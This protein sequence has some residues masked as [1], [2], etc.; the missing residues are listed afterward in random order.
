METVKHKNKMKK[1]SICPSTEDILAIFK[2]QKR[3]MRIDGFLKTARLSRACK[4]EILDILGK[5]TEKGQL[6]HLPGGGWALPENAGTLT[7]IFQAKAGGGGY[8][9]PDNPDL[10]QFPIHQVHVRGAWNGDRV[11]AVPPV[12][13]SRNGR[14]AEILKRN[15]EEIVARVEKKQ[16]NKFYCQPSDRK[17]AVIFAVSCDT[18]KC[19]GI[20]VG[21]M[22]LLKP[23]KRLNDSTWAAELIKIFGPENKISVQEAIVKTAHKVPAKFPALALDQAAKLGAEQTSAKGREDLRHAQFVTIDGKDAKD[24]DDAIYV[25]RQGNEWLLLVAIADVSHYVRPDKNPE[26][27]DQEAFRRGNS[28]YFPSSVEPMLPE[29]LSNGLCSLRPGEDRLV[30]FTEIRLS[31]DG[32]V[33]SARFAQGLIRSQARLIYDDVAAFFQ[34]GDNEAAGIEPHIA[35]MLQE[36]HELYKILARKR[37]ERGS[38]DF[39]L[40]EP[41]YDFNQ[42]GE[43]RKMTIAERNDAHKLIEE[44]MISANEA[45]AR[46]LGAAKIPFLYRVHPEPE[47]EKLLALKETLQK[48]G[49]DNAATQLPKNGTF[50]PASIQKIL[51]AAAGT[52][53]EYLVNK[54][55]LR[56]MQQARYQP[57]NVGHFGLASQAYCHFTSP[58]RRYADLLVHRALKASMGKSESKQPDHDKLVE[59]GEQLNNLERSALECEREMARR[60]GCQALKGHE[61]ETLDGTISGVTDFGAF[62]EFRDIPTEGLIRLPDL[63]KDW[64]EFDAKTQSLRGMHTGKTW[65]LGQSLKVKVAD[66]NTDRL[67]IRLLPDGVETRDSGKRQLNN[68]PSRKGQARRKEKKTSSGFRK[69]G[70]TPEK[71]TRNSGQ[72]RKR[73]S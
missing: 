27:L 45:A 40:P 42:E 1:N 37:R 43:L 22:V 52:P 11:R 47:P 72:S 58:I 33:L 3:H 57:E 14:I 48:T 68:P 2:A 59:I 16:A 51:K 65:M 18:E 6:V 4:K 8:F 13:V 24:F 70:K 44:F 30:L 69:P 7:G 39:D 9:V 64:F 36:A 49:I 15:T 62:V 20:N 26:S 61:G 66:V 50:Q 55:C 35:E 10:E 56:S 5:L 60:L 31:A 46:H 38:L 19:H 28:W 54:L 17:L 12:K 41:Q 73:H 21:D 32:D 67:E 29:A 34:T 71:S 63:G 53:Q 25:E 23:L